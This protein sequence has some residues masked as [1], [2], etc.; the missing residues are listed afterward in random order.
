MPATS[1]RLSSDFRL[2]QAEHIRQQPVRT[3][4]ACRKLAK[5]R[6]A[7]VNKLPFSD[8]RNNQSAFVFRLSG[9]VRFGKRIVFG[10]ERDQV[11]S[12]PLLQPAFK[13]GG[14]DLVWEVK[15]RVF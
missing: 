12:I 13:I 2:R 14:R 7:A 11:V 15:D 5:E 6:I 9:V 4:D 1:W 10:I 8:I 3:R